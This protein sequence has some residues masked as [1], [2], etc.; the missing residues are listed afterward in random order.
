MSHLWTPANLNARAGTAS[1]SGYG[2]GLRIVS[3]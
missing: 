2:Y 1:I 3:D